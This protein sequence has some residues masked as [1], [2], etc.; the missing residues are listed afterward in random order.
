M[1]NYYNTSSIRARVFRLRYTYIP[2][3]TP[4][5]CNNRTRTRFFSSLCQQLIEKPHRH[6]GA[7]R[8]RRR[9]TAPPPLASVRARHGRVTALAKLK[10]K[11]IKYLQTRGTCSS[12]L[13]ISSTLDKACAHGCLVCTRRIKRDWKSSGKKTTSARTN[14]RFR[15]TDGGFSRTIVVDGDISRLERLPQPGWWRSS[16]STVI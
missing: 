13:S 7:V 4:R 14:V 11:I 3:D 6:T 12:R 1:Y 15:V 8:G 5:L 10:Y 2:A 9:G 16:L